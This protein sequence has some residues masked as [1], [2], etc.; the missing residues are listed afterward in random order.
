MCRLAARVDG[1]ACLGRLY[2]RRASCRRRVDWRPGARLEKSLTEA[3]VALITTAGS[4]CREIPRL[5]G[6]RLWICCRLVK[7]AMHLTI[8]ES[9]GNGNAQAEEV[10]RFFNATVG[11]MS[12]MEDH[13]QFAVDSGL[14]R[15]AFRDFG[16]SRSA[17]ALARL[18]REFLS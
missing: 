8:Q 3:R 12:A 16:L 18:I 4:I 1:A 13:H 14:L 10:L 7:V 5:R 11:N 9:T 6:K 15:H 17:L 2:S